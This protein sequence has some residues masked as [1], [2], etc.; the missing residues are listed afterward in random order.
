MMKTEYFSVHTF[1]YT[2][3]SFETMLKSLNEA[4][5]KQIELYASAPHLCEMYQY[6]ELERK[7][8]LEEKK[9]LLDK[10]GVCVKSLFLPTLDCPVILR[11][12]TR[13]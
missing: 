9:K 2:H 11:M 8:M 10:Y 7:S 6:T 13:K 1:Y 4:H 5:V 12:K 3:N